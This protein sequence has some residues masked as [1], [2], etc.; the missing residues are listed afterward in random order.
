MTWWCSARGLPWDWSWDAYPG[1]WV[2]A[3]LIG[4]IFWRFRPKGSDPW[5][6]AAIPS[7]TLLLWMTLDWPAGPLGAGYLASVHSGQFLMLAMVIPPLLLYGVDRA[8]LAGVLERRPAVSRVLNAVT[9]PL[10]AIVAFAVSM[11]VS[12][13]PTVVDSLMQ[14]QA[15]AFAL[16]AI[17]LVAGVIFWWPI[18]VRVP[19]RPRFPPLMQMLY[20][21]FGTQPHLYIAM[22]LL[23]ADFP[24]YATYELAPRV[25]LLSAMTDQQIAGA[26]MLAFGGTYVLAAISVL[27]FKWN[28]SVSAQD[29]PGATRNA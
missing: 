18:I 13:L 14:S 19:E 23:G 16:D 25:T 28:A 29:V 9:R 7:A 5:R 15:G 6:R 21:F 2:F 8:R 10:F 4:A 22:W 1:V 12:H 27:F 11:V 20:L 3:L 17:W 26:V 24:A